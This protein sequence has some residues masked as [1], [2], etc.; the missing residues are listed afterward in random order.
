MNSV[1][2]PKKLLITGC[3][4]SGTKYITVLL[5]QLGMDIGHECMG[6]DGIASWCMT[7]NSEIVPWGPSAK[8]YNF[9][10]V[11]HQVRHPLLVF[12]S[13]QSFTDQSWQYIYNNIPYINTNDPDIIKYAK[14]WYFWNI[15]T[16]KKAT[17][18]YQIEIINEISEQF[19]QY[20]DIKHNL[21]K[22]ELLDKNIN[23]RYYSNIFKFLKFL[24]DK[25]NIEPPSLIRSH[26][27]KNYSTKIKVYKWEDLGNVD[28]EL[29]Q[30]V[31]SKAIEY[32]YLI[33]DNE[34]I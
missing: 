12:S 28:K 23:T 29:A 22:F 31:Q 6:K 32:G 4:R 9:E 26:A 34:L 16:E 8:D 33:K 20:L 27:R 17:W 5:K 21:Q 24:Y 15:E 10:H 7:I 14:Y 1:K 25:L 18:R 30:K 11:F 13:L 2:I 3:G 19:C